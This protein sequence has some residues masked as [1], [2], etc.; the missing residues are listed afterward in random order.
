MRCKYCKCVST[1]LVCSYIAPSGKLWSAMMRNY[2][3][4]AH[5]CFAAHIQRSR[6]TGTHHVPGKTASRRGPQPPG[7]RFKRRIKILLVRPQPV[8]KGIVLSLQSQLSGA[9]QLARAD[10]AATRTAWR[11]SGRKSQASG[12]AGCRADKRAGKRVAKRAAK[13]LV[14]RPDGQPSGRAARRPS[15]GSSGRTAKRLGN[16]AEIRHRTEIGPK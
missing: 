8:G 11:A 1:R 6:V 12:Q 15:E 9:T 10:I 4:Q 5:A 7:L 16:T 13:R 14:G 2:F 3:A